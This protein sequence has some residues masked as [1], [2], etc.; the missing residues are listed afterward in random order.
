VSEE[1]SS[2]TVEEVENAPDSKVQSLE[3]YVDSGFSPSRFETV[4]PPPS[5]AEFTAMS[6]A[7]VAGQSSE[8]GSSF[9]KCFETDE[10]PQHYRFLTEGEEELS[11]PEEEKTVPLSEVERQLEQVREEAYQQAKAEL[12]QTKTEELAALKQQL[13]QFMDAIKTEKAEHF[14]L[15]EQKALHI[16]LAVAKKILIQTAEVKPDYIVKVI[17]RGIDSLG[18]EN[19]TRIRVSPTDMEFLEVIGLPPELSAGELGIEYVPDES[20]HSGCVIETDFGEVDLQLEHMW[21]QVREE[22]FEA[23][24]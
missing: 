16:A 2:E 1:F 20:V 13:E 21:E 24:K 10:K 9:F 3:D 8:S 22:L 12:E 23:A 14:S 19:P 5:K 18:A 4:G 11:E 7:V 17:A 6:I 15:L